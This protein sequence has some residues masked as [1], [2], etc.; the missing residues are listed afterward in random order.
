MNSDFIVGMTLGNCYST[1]ILTRSLLP[2]LIFSLLVLITLSQPLYSQMPGDNKSGQDNFIKFRSELLKEHR[3]AKADSLTEPR[4]AKLEEALLFIEQNNI[5]ERLRFGHHHFFPNFGGLTTGSGLALGVRYWNNALVENSIVFWSVTWSTKG[6]QQY[7][8]GL[9]SRPF[10]STPLTIGLDSRYR[11]FPQEDYFGTGPHSSKEDEANYR[12]EDF[13]ANAKLT[14]NVLSY[15]DAGLRVGYLKSRTASGT[16]KESPSVDEVFTGKDIPPGFSENI[17]HRVIGIMVNLDLRDSPGNPRSGVGLFFDH[18]FFKD[19]GSDRY[20]F[21]W[22]SFEFQGYLPFFHKHR[23]FAL[24]VRMTDTNGNDGGEIPFY[25]MPFIGGHQSIRGFKEFRFRDG[26][27]LLLNL[28]YRFEA[29]MGLEMALF[30]DLG[31]V[32]RSWDG[33]R[34]SSF[35]SSYGA[36]FRFNTAQSVFLRLDVGHGREGTRFFFKFGNVF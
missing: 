30:G 28:E 6:Y 3:R 26:K 5:I 25:Y 14:L 31:Q 11:N 16:S 33:F 22:S 10:K 23:I 4:K 29:F 35:E 24:R 32:G 17:K 12:L 13:S 1:S 7:L 15:L 36:G 21:R 27:A 19:A 9:N 8:A 2:H 20:D 18:S 34:L